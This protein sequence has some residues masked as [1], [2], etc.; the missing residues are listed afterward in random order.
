MNNDRLVAISLNPLLVVNDFLEIIALEREMLLTE[1]SFTGVTDLG[2]PKHP[3]NKKSM[4]SINNFFITFSLIFII[5][6]KIIYLGSIV[7]VVFF[8]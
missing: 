6:R 8:V 1:K 5:V 2:M 7:I 3:V 4:V